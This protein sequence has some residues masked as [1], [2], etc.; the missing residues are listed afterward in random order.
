[1]EKIKE[2]RSRTG[3]GVVD[4]QKAIEESGGD[5]ILA[6]EIL[7]KKGIAKAAERSDRD[8]S[9]GIILVDRSEDGKEGYILEINSETDFV[10]RNRQFQEFSKKIFQLI[11]NNKPSSL[12]GLISLPMDGTTVK[13]GLDNLSGIIGEKLEIRRFEILSG[14]TV[15]AYS[16]LGGKISVLVSLNKENIGKLARDMAMQIAAINPKYITPED[17]LSAETEKEK[18][19][20][21]EQLEKEGKPENII[22]KIL[23]GKINKYFEEVCLVKQEYIKDDK[24][25]VEDILGEVKVE[26][27]IRYSL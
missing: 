15:A 25:R 24:K 22:D 3:A 5:I 23:D 27:F 8:V 21:R 1:M 6:Q 12:E 20:Y 16:H 13:E 18:E 14:P 17:V 26:K 7:R 4:C 9:E 19:I 2:L 11:K 10:A